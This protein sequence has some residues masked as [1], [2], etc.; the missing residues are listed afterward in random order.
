MPMRNALW[1]NSPTSQCTGSNF[2]LVLPG[3]APSWRYRL[4]PLSLKHCT[5]NSVSSLGAGPR[6]PQE[7]PCFSRQQMAPVPVAVSFTERCSQ[8]ALLAPPQLCPTGIV[9]SD[10]SPFE[11]THSH[12]VECR[13][14]SLSKQKATWAQKMVK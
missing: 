12:P 8:N 10:L 2:W 14:T 11:M 7:K 6:L 9:S 1:G 13:S 3:H 5:G 4:P